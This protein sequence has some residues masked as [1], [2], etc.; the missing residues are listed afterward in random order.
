MLRSRLLSVRQKSTVVSSKL[1]TPPLN[2][3]DDVKRTTLE[4]PFARAKVGPFFQEAPTLGN[5]FSQDPTLQGY[6]KRY[7][8]KEVGL[9]NTTIL[10][11]L[12]LIYYLAPSD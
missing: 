1:D 11:L 4:I 8:P 12:V 7:M 9:I 5:Q 3:T 6:L 2:Q 10:S